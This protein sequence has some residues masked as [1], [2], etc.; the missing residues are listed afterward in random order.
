MK[1]KKFVMLGRPKG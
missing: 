1:P